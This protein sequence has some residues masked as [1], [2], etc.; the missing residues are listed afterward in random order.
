MPLSL[1][2]R[3]AEDWRSARTPRRYMLQAVLT[4]AAATANTTLAAL[5]KL[6]ANPDVYISR[7]RVHIYHSA[8]ITAVAPLGWKRISTVANGTLMTAADIP[9]CDSAAAN[10]SLEVRTGS[11]ITGT[12]AN[13]YILA[14]P[15]T[16]TAVPAAATGGGF[17]DDWTARD[18]SERIKLTGTEGLALELAGAYDVDL[19]VHLLL[20]WEEVS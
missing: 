12:K 13:Q 4:P 2:L 8:A 15:A 3:T 17:V 18:L 9:K 14:H 19:R 10:A 16:T 7:I 5:D 6:A 1:G 20:V 11:G